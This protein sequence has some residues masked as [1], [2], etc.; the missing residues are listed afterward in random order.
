MSARL[1]PLLDAVRSTIAVPAADPRRAALLVAVA[2]ILFAILALA[3]LILFTPSRR[4]VVKV[5]SYR[6]DDTDEG[7]QDS[8]AT[9]SEENPSASTAEAPE[10]PTESST[11]EAVEGAAAGEAAPRPRKPKPKPKSQVALFLGAVSVWLAPVLLLAALV[12][13][14]YFTGSD[15]YCAKTCH[16]NQESVILA[17]RTDH[18]SCV[19]C[20]E[21]PAGISTIPLNVASRVGMVVSQLRGVAPTSTVVDSRACLRC[22]QSAMRNVVTSS[23]GI[24]MSHAETNAA[25]TVCTSCHP[26]AGHSNLRTQSMSTCL[27]CHDGKKASADCATCHVKQPLA[28]VA[29]A[30]NAATTTLGSGKVTFP[31]VDL[32]PPNCAGC[33]DLKTQCDTCHG[34]RMPHSDEFIKGGHAVVAAFDGKQVCQ[35]CH[36]VTFCSDCHK[37]FDS[38][39]SPTWKVDHQK[40]AWNEGCSCHPRA[41]GS[42]WCYQCHSSTPPHNLLK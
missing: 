2:L 23:T 40:F 34:V 29:V 1:Q 26:T 36:S 32:G 28:T 10:A 21:P 22:H 41:Q 16:A 3:V 20:H 31:L 38:A 27:V 37:S 8:E 33:H 9:A 15:T 24:R 6:P 17:G 12:F 25:G 42:T 7:V 18:A 14:Y 19:A 5:R 35:K 13:G 30:S 11:I 4:K 39:H